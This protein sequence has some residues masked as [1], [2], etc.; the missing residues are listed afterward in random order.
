MKP[1]PLW[2][3]Q[4]LVHQV[5]G[6]HSRPER[7]A[8][9]AAEAGSGLGCDS[10]EG[11]KAHVPTSQLGLWANLGEQEP[12]RPLE[13]CPWSS[14]GWGRGTSPFLIPS[15]LRILQKHTQYILATALLYDTSPYAILI[16]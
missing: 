15:F 6:I 4:N 3:S 16:H 10:S 7:L 5:T 13:T 2:P 14:K 11:T 8:G 12:S 1:A 9:G